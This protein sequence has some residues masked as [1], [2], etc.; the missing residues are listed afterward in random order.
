MIGMID[1]RD[2]MSVFYNTPVLVLFLV[3]GT[4]T[5]EEYVTIGGRD[6]TD[7]SR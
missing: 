4:P 6:D 1:E 5:A 7:T 2:K 3:R